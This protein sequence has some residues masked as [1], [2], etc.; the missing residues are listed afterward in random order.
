MEAVAL[1]DERA[2]ATYL[3]CGALQQ[4]LHT[5]EDKEKLLVSL[6]ETA[7][8]TPNHNISRLT[9]APALVLL[10]E[11]TSESPVIDSK[12]LVRLLTSAFK[13]IGIKAQLLTSLSTTSKA[14]VE[15][16]ATPVEAA[17]AQG[18]IFPM[19]ATSRDRAISCL[20]QVIEAATRNHILSTSAIQLFVPLL[21]VISLEKSSSI[22]LKNN[23]STALAAMIDSS[24]IIEEEMAICQQLNELTT[25]FKL[26]FKHALL[27]V[28]PRAGRKASRLIVGLGVIFLGRTSLDE[29]TYITSPSFPSL[30]SLLSQRS[31][32]VPRSN[33]YID[34]QTDYDQL[35]ASIKIL[36]LVLSDLHR[37]YLFER[38][39]IDQA[40]AE[41]SLGMEQEQEVEEGEVEM[42]DVPSG[43]VPGSRAG[44]VAASVGGSVRAGLTRTEIDAMPIMSPLEE[45][46]VDCDKKIVDAR[47][48]DLGRTAAKAFLLNLRMSVSYR[49]VKYKA[50]YLRDRAGAMRILEE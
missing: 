29:E 25:P 45:A 41:A 17:V 13:A 50:L 40:Q 5:I 27:S 2:F 48:A 38:R 34:S 16:Q 37:V 47:A 15:E 35:V 20:T 19:S 30:L 22:S 14:R 28:L 31:D 33:F 49:T 43:S 12:T 4:C 46:I 8:L 23:I 7:T 9:L 39:R 36:T 24:S 18:A 44:S 6:I 1:R 3:M 26:T 32:K 11:S 10:A 42:K 21:A